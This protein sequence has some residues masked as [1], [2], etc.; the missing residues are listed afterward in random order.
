MTNQQIKFYPAAPGLNKNTETAP[1]PTS[2][3]L[4]EWYRKADRFAVDPR[5]EKF[6]E[7]PDGT[8][9]FPTWKACPAIFDVM[10]TGYV[11]VTPCEIEFF[12]DDNKKISVKILEK[13][14]DGFV[15]E[16]PPM[17]QFINPVNC[18]EDHFAWFPQWAPQLPDGYSALYLSPL[19][20]FDLPFVMT[21]G[22]IDN[23]K[24]NLPGSMPFFLQNNFSGIIKKGTPF[25]QII[26]FKRENWESEIVEQDQKTLYNR[27]IDNSRFYRKKDGGIYKNKIWSKREYK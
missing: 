24:V 23:D 19:N 4:P 2:K 5:T 12:L 1:K 10:T 20:R 16:R 8:G 26:P 22:I 9:K 17:P 15:T 6:W 25:A 13:G 21:S 3:V 14:F 7:N 27:I 11:L 18:Y